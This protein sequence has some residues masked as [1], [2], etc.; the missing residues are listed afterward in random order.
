MLKKIYNNLRF[1]ENC[2]ILRTYINKK[3][4]TASLQPAPT[5]IN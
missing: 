4:R 3:R 2:G 1:I 5:I